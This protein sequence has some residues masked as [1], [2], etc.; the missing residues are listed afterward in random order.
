MKRRYKILLFFIAHVILMLVIP[1]LSVELSADYCGMGFSMLM[2]FIVYPI[3]SAAVGA[4]S[5]TDIKYLWWMPLVSAAVFP[6]L[7]SLAMSDI[8]IWDL[9]FYSVFYILRGYASAGVF[10]LIKYMLKKINNKRHKNNERNRK[11]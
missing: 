4:V 6:P 9:Y 10:V 1:F 2:F 5:A 8:M 11:K 3:L 7:F